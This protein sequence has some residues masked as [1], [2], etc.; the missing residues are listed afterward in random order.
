MT[1]LDSGPARAARHARCR[2]R[3]RSA[4]D[5]DAVGRRRAP[6][7]G[8]IARNDANAKV[9]L[10]IGSKNFTEQRVLGEIY[11]QGLQAAGYTIAKDLDLG[12]EK[13]ALAA[14]KADEIDAYPEYTGTALLSFFGKQPDELPKDPEPGLRRRPSR[15]SRPTG[16]SRSRRR[17]SR[18][19]TRSP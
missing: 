11:A 4:A 10:T 12:D 1:I 7:A 8:K 6:A 14:L 13:V 17:R 3:W 2:R 18:R 19:P 16:W 9:K 5:R 15:T